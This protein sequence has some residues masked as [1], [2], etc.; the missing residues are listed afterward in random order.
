MS[1]AG[2]GWGSVCI[3]VLACTLAAAPAGAPFV[4]GPVLFTED[5][6]QGLAHWSSELEKPGRVSVC[7][8]VLTIDVPAGCTLWF[9]PELRGAVMIEYQ[10]RMVQAGGR[11]DRVSDLNAFW[12]ATDARTPDDLFA[13]KRSG[14]FSDYNQLRAY[15]VGQGGNGNTTTRFRR[16]IGDA[17]DRPLLPEHDLRSAD[18]L[19]QPNVWQT[20]QLVAFGNRIQYYRDGR[21]IFDFL[22]PAPYTR[23]RFGFRTT[24]SHV[25]LRKLRVY[26]IAAASADIGFPRTDS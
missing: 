26:R 15:Y 11:N 4:Q 5:F 20:V 7:G 17:A 6:R 1:L 16:Y 25:E 14:K 23:G 2:Q 9:R 19:L 3:G 10:A 21:L 8:G 12:M 13:T 24:S 22:D 18:V